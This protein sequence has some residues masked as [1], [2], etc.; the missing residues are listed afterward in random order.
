MHCR[1]GLYVRSMPTVWACQMITH[2][3]PGT[4]R[5]NAIRAR[6]SVRFFSSR[7]PRGEP[8][9]PGPQAFAIRNWRPVQRLSDEAT[10]P[11][12]GL[13]GREGVLRFSS[14]C[15]IGFLR[16]QPINLGTP[17]YTSTCPVETNSPPEK[18]VLHVSSALNHYRLLDHAGKDQLAVAS[19][20]SPCRAWPG[21]VTL[22][23]CRTR[24]QVVPLR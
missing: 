6:L 21:S 5:T 1:A 24:N 4:S 9:C 23:L 22:P 20:D 12:R 3:S 17:P 16:G 14:C 2:C 15:V 10:E 8:S 18:Q 19:P 13:L 7:G 11:A